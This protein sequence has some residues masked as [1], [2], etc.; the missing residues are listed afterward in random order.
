[1]ADEPTGNLDAETA[2]MVISLLLQSVEWGMGLIVCSHDHAV[3]HALSKQ[4]ALERG[5]L[6]EY[7]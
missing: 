7:N 2:Q 3:A 1:L 5:V 6:V 4:L